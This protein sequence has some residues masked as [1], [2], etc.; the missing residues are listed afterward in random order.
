MRH[1]Q[2]EARLVD[3]CSYLFSSYHQW[4]KYLSLNYAPIACLTHSS[5]C[6]S[7]ESRL[8][9]DCLLVLRQTS[10]GKQIL[11]LG[12]RYVKKVLAVDFIDDYL[13]VIKLFLT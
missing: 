5:Q 10:F 13:K 11:N 4:L 9:S 2:Y 8:G 6:W 12:Y 1:F 3:P 7:E